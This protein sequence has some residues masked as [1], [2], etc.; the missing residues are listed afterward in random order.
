MRSINL[1]ILVIYFVGNL[2]SEK[3]KQ[4]NNVCHV[5][6]VPL[7][8]YI[9]RPLSALEKTH[10]FRLTLMVKIRFLLNEFQIFHF[11]QRLLKILVIKKTTMYIATKTIWSIFFFKKFKYRF[12]YIL[13]V[14]VFH[15]PWRLGYC[16][17]LTW[18]LK[19]A[20]P[21]AYG[22]KWPFFPSHEKGHIPAISVSRQAKS[23]AVQGYA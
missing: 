12:Q 17:R 21:L 13:P 14:R 1:L 18:S 22:Y 2:D 23:W 7:S 10:R 8:R 9:A 11:P 6:V 20:F 16:C 15:F 3:I 5:R 4:L 19:L